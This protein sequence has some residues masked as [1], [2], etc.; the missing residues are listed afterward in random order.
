SV[1]APRPSS[2][3]RQRRG[4]PSTRG[5]GGASSSTSRRAPYSSARPRL[6]GFVD[7]HSLIIG[8]GAGVGGAIALVIVVALIFRAMWRVAEPNEAMII[9]GFKHEPVEGV[10]ESMGFK[11]VTGKGVL[12]L[13]GFQ[14]VRTLSLDANET[15]LNI[16]CVT[17]QGIPVIVKAVVIYKVGD[18]FVSI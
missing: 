16:T 15:E 12:V 3:M 17:T 14:R 2:P 4:R 11:I 10:G 9:S 1:V 7:M 6:R 13:P 5:P 18:D 8:A